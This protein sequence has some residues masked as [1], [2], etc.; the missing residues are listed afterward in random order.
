M[1]AMIKKILMVAMLA[2]MA[3][4]AAEARPDT[5]DQLLRAPKGGWE[6]KIELDKG[7]MR[8]VRDGL[9]EQDKGDMRRVRSSPI[10][11][12]ALKTLWRLFFGIG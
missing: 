8:R 11:G 3:S 5:P 2:M 10:Q 7:D 1:K 9:I 4:S 6:Q 12:D